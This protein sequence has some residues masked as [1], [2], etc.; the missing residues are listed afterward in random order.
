ME[1]KN[2]KIEAEDVQGKRDAQPDGEKLRIWDNHNNSLNLKLNGTVK[3][4][5]YRDD[6]IPTL[7][8]PGEGS[9]LVRSLSLLHDAFEPP[10]KKGEGNVIGLGRQEKAATILGYEVLGAEDYKT[11]FKKRIT[12]DTVRDAIH[13]Y[14]QEYRTFMETLW[15]D[16]I[17]FSK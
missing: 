1:Y 8:V 2:W 6:G 5:D 17:H 13:I 10:Y 9:I 11:P 3:L 7:D 12:A 4:P 14:E 16:A 15:D